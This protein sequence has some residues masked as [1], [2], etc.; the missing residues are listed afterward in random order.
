MPG[1]ANVWTH[2]LLR[3]LLPA[4]NTPLKP[5]PRQAA[6]RV[7]VRRTTRVGAH[8]GELLEDLGVASD[9]IHHITPDDLLN[10]NEDLIEA[11]AGLMRGR[12]AR[13]LEADV[14]PTAEGVTIQVRSAN[15]D[16]IDAYINKRPVGSQDV[17]HDRCLFHVPHP[18][19][20][21][22]PQ[23]RLE[24]FEGGGLAA[25]RLAAMPDPPG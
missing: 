6:F 20:G 18:V 8:A 17:R 15:L 21:R 10:D 13:C 16:R 11:A 1:G 7:A 9:E 4:R 25:V 19:M 22:N 14:E 24:G 3:Q 12:R 23:L 2:D 5:L